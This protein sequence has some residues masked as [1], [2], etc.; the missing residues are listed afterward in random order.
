MSVPA[1]FGGQSFQ[2]IALEKLRQLRR[3]Q[4]RDLLLEIDGGVNNETIGRC[5]EAGAQLC[6]VGSAI[7]K[8]E[9]YADAVEQLSRQAAV[10]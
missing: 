9:N 6:V 8:R 3:T 2:D 10:E 1:G 7:F 5:V 4:R